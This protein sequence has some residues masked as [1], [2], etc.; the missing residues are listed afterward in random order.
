[1]NNH[2]ATMIG[3]GVI[4]VFGIQMSLYELTKGQ[5]NPVLLL[6]VLILGSLLTYRGFGAYVRHRQTEK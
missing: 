3:F 2:V 6:I 5:A 4:G 1:M